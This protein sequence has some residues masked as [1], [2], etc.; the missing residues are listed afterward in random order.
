VADGV[1]A[2]VKA[3]EAAD[4]QAVLDRIDDEPRI[5][6]LC[7]RDHAVLRRGKLSERQI[8]RRVD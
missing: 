7:T 8:W 1:D 6:E 2:V 3:M 4:P 5:E